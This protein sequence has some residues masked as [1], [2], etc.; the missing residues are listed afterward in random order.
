MGTF[1]LK[2]IVTSAYFFIYVFPLLLIKEVLDLFGF[3][4]YGHLPKSGVFFYVWSLLGLAGF[5]YV[6]YAS[7]FRAELVVD[8]HE[9]SH[10]SLFNAHTITKQR[11]KEEFSII[12]LIKQFLQLINPF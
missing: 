9:E 11:F 7:H 6:L 5:F 12:S 3:D 4:V 8:A 2:Q 10:V 1:I